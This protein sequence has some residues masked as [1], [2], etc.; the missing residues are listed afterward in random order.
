[1]CG[2]SSSKS[3]RSLS[4]LLMSSCFR[5]DKE[6]GDLASVREPILL[7]VYGRLLQ[8]WRN[9]RFFKNGVKLTRGYSEVDDVS[10][11][12][13]QNRCA[14]LEKPSGDRIRIRLL[15]WTVRQSS[16]QELCFTF[17]PRDANG[18][19]RSLKIVHGYNDPECQRYYGFKLRVP[20][21]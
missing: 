15:V 18:S 7:F 11:Y 8:Q 10:D 5:Y 14:L 6:V 21:R 3:S 13:D 9:D 1:M 2:I 4:H 12:G 17:L 19:S 20:S 16:L